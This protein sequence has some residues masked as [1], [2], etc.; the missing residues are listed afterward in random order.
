VHRRRNLGVLALVVCL[1]ASYSAP[2]HAGRPDERRPG[3]ADG[4][5]VGDMV[6][7]FGFSIEGGAGGSTGG[8]VFSLHVDG[9]TVTAGNYEA[10]ATGSFRSEA[11]P[12]T[13]E[14]TFTGSGAISG[15]AE[16][17]IIENLAARVQGVVTVNGVSAPV[18]FDVSGGSM[19][20]TILSATCSVVIGT[21]EPEVRAA[22]A[23][24]VSITSL[25][26]RFVATRVSAS[27]RERTED[28]STEVIGLITAG[29][30]FVTSVAGG[31]FD[32]AAL[33]DLLQR[34]EHLAETIPRNRRCRTAG[35]GDH[36]STVAAV[37]R[38][39]LE[40]MIANPD[41]YGA[42]ELRA[43]LEAAVRTGL[44]GPSGDPTLLA[45]VRGV[46]GDQL[47]AAIAAG[48]DVDASILGA[49]ANM[50]GWRAE[51]GR[52]ASAIGGGS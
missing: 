22:V 33:L 32:R 47:D 44:A 31:S 29:D 4:E 52:A 18:N 5:W 17:P 21:V 20:I 46:L 10:S 15:S 12:A 6:A 36:L 11:P 51:A 39:L 38:N 23:G 50:M 49:A 14:G 30:A 25:S 37:V 19:V 35:A 42:T 1:V 7:G 13:G 16:E 27:G 48:D 26:S 34:A 8:G 3:F 24:T 28:F 9:G 40:V 43:A 2:L 45:D 41:A